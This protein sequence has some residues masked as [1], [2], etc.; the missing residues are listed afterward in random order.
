MRK[1]APQGMLGACIIPPPLQYIYIIYLKLLL[2][3]KKKKKVFTS[4]FRSL[5]NLRMYA[6]FCFVYKAHAV[7]L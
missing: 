3:K 6:V 2:L 4:L 1:T 7:K 5:L